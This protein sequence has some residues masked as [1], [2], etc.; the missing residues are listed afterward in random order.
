MPSYERIV[1]GGSQLLAWQLKD[2]PVLIVGG[3]QVAADR[4][5]CVL[6][7][8]AKVTLVSPASGLGEEVR[9]RLFSEQWPHLTYIDRI[10]QDDDVKGQY[11]V[12]TALDDST[13]SRH[14][15]SLC[16]QQKI[17]VNVADVIPLCDFFFGSV[18]RRG[19]LQVMV[20]TGGKG[21]RIA[22]R[23]RKMIEDALPHDCGEAIE[24]VGTLRAELRRRAPAQEEGK[25]RMAWMVRVCDRWSLEQLAAMDDAMREKILDG[26]EDDRALYYADV[27][28]ASTLASI[29]LK[30]QS[31]WRRC[32]YS[33]AAGQFGI[34]AGLMGFSFGIASTLAFQTIRLKR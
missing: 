19:P 25:R 29:S 15:H 21:P 23:I 33:R 17:I 26:W 27:T 22:N 11:M 28:S 20:S 8:D 4:L 14:I 32:P 12:L 2:Q 5:R 18:I 10:F 16:K 6:A 1:T 34:L 30:W 3:G 13:I 7:A 31:L 9:Y 24:N